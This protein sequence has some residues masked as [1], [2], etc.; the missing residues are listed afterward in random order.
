[1]NVAELQQRFNEIRTKKWRMVEHKEPV[2][3]VGFR[4]L[5]SSAVVIFASSVS[6]R[7]YSIEAGSLAEFLSPEHSPFIEEISPYAGWPMDAKIRVWN[8]PGDAKEARHF[9][10][11]NDE[12]LP[13]AW[14]NGCTSHT[15]N[16]TAVWCHAE[17]VEGAK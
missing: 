5:P 4:W 10:G 15:T 14:L 1:M 11:E 3:P 9:A 17:L 8:L 13:L 16:I 7:L 2:E 12:G 6:N